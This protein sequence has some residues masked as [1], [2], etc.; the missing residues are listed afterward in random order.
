MLLSNDT[1]GEILRAA[2][3]DGLSA[4]KAVEI[5]DICNAW[6]AK[7]I[8]CESCEGD[9]CVGCKDAGEAPG[10]KFDPA[11]FHVEKVE[12]GHI[13]Y[14]R[15][16]DE[17]I[18]LANLE[19][20]PED[21]I[22]PQAAAAVIEIAKEWK[23]FRDLNGKLL[24]DSKSDFE[25]WAKH[26]PSFVEMKRAASR[27]AKKLKMAEDLLEKQDKTIKEKENQLKEL[28]ERIDSLEKKS[29]GNAGI[30]T[31]TY[32]P[33]PKQEIQPGRKAGVNPFKADRDDIPMFPESVN[34][35]GSIP[36]GNPGGF[37]DD[38][39]S[40]GRGTTG[41]HKFPGS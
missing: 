39:R 14:S 41:I 40:I 1:H 4:Q 16:S 5:G 35:I 28:R 18:Y 30:V 20:A 24:K 29:R 19:N 27:T 26:I 38:N 34:F 37:I 13:R 9:V 2:M 10:G 17:E 23:R 12:D 36:E 7:Y 11:L 33:Q 32:T 31:T 6:V 8:R 15:K 22:D 25:A 3:D 21:L